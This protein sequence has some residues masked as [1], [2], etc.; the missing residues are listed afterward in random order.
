MPLDWE[1]RS[2]PFHAKQQNFLS[3]Y[4][5]AAGWSTCHFDIAI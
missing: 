1:V 3:F 2:M 5:D 4:D